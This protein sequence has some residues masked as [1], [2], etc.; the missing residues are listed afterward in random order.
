MKQLKEASGGEKADGMST[1]QGFALK[2]PSLNQTS[3]FSEESLAARQPS[4]SSTAS[5]RESPELPGSKVLAPSEKVEVLR[6]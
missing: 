6:D 1:P 5:S 4:C 3:K 2:G